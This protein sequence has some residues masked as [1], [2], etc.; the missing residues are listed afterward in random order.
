[1]GIDADEDLLAEIVASLAGMP[2]ADRK[3]NKRA[4]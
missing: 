3:L 1:L 4:L 2:I